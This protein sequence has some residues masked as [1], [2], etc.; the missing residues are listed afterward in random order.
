MG[1]DGVISLLVVV[2]V[3]GAFWWWL[4]HRPSGAESAAEPVRPTVTTAPRVERTT[5][6]T[7]ARTVVP[8]GTYTVQWV[9]DGDTIAIGDARGTRLAKVRILGLNAP[10]LAH[11]GVKAECFASESTDRLRTLLQD[12]RVRLVD[13]TRAPERDRFL[14]R[15]AHVEVGGRDVTELMIRGGFAVESHLRS[16]GPGDRT[17]AYVAAQREAVRAKRG[18]WGACPARPDPTLGAY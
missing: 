2:L 17:D 13:D 6:P 5:G 16:A 15:L 18:L 7:S 1:N 14:R 12:E 10:E 4:G 9:F 8:A 3:G 11:N